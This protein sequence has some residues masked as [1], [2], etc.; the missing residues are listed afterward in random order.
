MPS[1][2]ELPDP[3]LLRKFR[4]AVHAKLTRDVETERAESEARRG[5]VLA[6]LVPAIAEARDL[7]LCGRTWLFGSFAWGKPTQE[8]DIDLAVEDCP[9]PFA[10]A[11]LVGRRCRRD[12][13][14]VAVEDLPEGLEKRVL[15]EGK[16]L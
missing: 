15:H 13:H 2:R 14:A 1:S 6:L 3:D 11:S 4:Q 12:V 9:D 10:V 7:G 5:Q 8:S 16:E